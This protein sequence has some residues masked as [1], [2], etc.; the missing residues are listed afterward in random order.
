MSGNIIT[1]SEAKRFYDVYSSYRT[2]NR[3]YYKRIPEDNLDFRMVDNRERKSDTPRESLVHQIDTERDYI[4]GVKS[5]ILN[6]KIPYEDL[7]DAGQLSKEELLLK[8]DKADEELVSLL[9]EPDINDKKV[10]VPWSKEQIT[11]VAALWGM[12]NH[13]I[14]HNG[15]NL[16][17]MDHLNIERFPELRT[18][19]G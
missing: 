8:L 13:E 4:N 10:K 6:F 17:L 11:A 14:L 15:W 2:I 19:W 5:G 12:N 18:M 3:E 7:T 16:A 1:N 9:S